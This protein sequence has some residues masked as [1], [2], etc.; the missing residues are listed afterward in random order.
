MI[1]SVIQLADRA[2]PAGLTGP[3][4]GGEPAAYKELVGF[5]SSCRSEDLIAIEAIAYRGARYYSTYQ[6][7]L[8][9]AHSDHDEHSAQHLAGKRFLADWLRDGLAYSSSER[10]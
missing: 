10:E 3:S 5:L 9:A 4:S 7:S 6:E 1:A 2:Y 8:A